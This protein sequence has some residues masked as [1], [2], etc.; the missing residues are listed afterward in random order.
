MYCY[1][2]YKRKVE[3]IKK[4]DYIML[5]IVKRETYVLLK[6]LLTLL[7]ISFSTMLLLVVRTQVHRN[8]RPCFNNVERYI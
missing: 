7:G 2:I 3:K 6:V 5:K 4:I 1:S 8:V